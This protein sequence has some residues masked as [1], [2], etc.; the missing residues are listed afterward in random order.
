MTSLFMAQITCLTKKGQRNPNIMTGLM[1]ARQFEAACGVLEIAA[2][3]KKK[4]R[5]F[6]DLGGL[7]L[8]FGFA[9]SPELF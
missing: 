4:R 7:L 1:I 5:F 3:F 9:E 2:G 6:E 8:V